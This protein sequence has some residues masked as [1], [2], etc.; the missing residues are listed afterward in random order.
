MCDQ[1]G[2]DGWKE[3]LLSRIAH[4]TTLII[5]VDADHPGSIDDL[6][7]ELEVSWSFAF[8]LESYTPVQSGDIDRSKGPPS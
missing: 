2:W 5:L 1:T 7:R 3:H 4:S 8:T 6:A